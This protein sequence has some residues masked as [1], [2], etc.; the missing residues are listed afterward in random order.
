MDIK[1][2]IL[3]NIANYIQKYVFPTESLYK[4]ILH[5]LPQP[6]LVKLSKTQG[7]MLSY[8]HSKT[9][10]AQTQMVFIMIF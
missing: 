8:I 3:K 9:G 6:S 1:N 10:Q 4:F 2:T 7:I 5:I